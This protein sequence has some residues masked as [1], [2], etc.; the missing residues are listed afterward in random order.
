MSLGCTYEGDNLV[1]LLQLARYLIKHAKEVRAGKKSNN[2]QLAQ[3]LYQTPQLRS[4]Y[5]GIHTQTQQAFE[6]LSLRLLL[7][8]FD[9][10]NKHKTKNAHS[11][12]WNMTSVDLTKV[13]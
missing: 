8:A 10:L 9:N 5:N 12:A 4:N 13:N 2:D 7:N 6:Y 1:M 3:Y 11:I